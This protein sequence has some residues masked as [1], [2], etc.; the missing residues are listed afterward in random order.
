MADYN[1]VEKVTKNGRT[2]FVMKVK[3]SNIELHNYGYHGNTDLKTLV[4]AGIIGMNGC[5]F[6]KNSSDKTTL[7]NIVYQG[8]VPLGSL[9]DNSDA[10]RNQTGKAVIYW[11][12]SLLKYADGISTVTDMTI[13]TAKSSWI[14]GGIGLYFGKSN[15]ETLMK[16]SMPEEDWNDLNDNN[17]KAYRTA[18]VA[19]TAGKVVYLIACPKTKVTFSELRK[20]ILSYLNVTESTASAYKGIT[21]DGGQSTQ[22][23]GYNELGVNG[24]ESPLFA[25]KV[26]QVIKNTYLNK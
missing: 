21:L 26:P 25:R 6:G 14:Q 23:R 8:G 16:N 7:N 5:F 13:P 3:A 24:V 19:D 12:G 11:T 9:T 22:I 2:F 1:I 17:G 4:S 20:D 15:W 18:M 10:K